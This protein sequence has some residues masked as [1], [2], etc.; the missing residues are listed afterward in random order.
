MR[1]CEALRAAQ[2]DGVVRDKGGLDAPV[3]ER[4]RNFSGGQRQRLGVA[5][6]LCMQPDI[7]ILD[8]ASSALDYA[9]DAA[10]RHAIR[11]LPYHPTVF[12]VSQRASSLRTAD[13]ILVLEDGRLAG[14]G[15]HDELLT[16]CPVYREIAASQDKKE[17]SVG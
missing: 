1:R 6:A 5:R 17:E 12:L 3:E 2:A 8:D 13:Q 7:L 10:M 14:A 4:G 16:N 15:T 11:A 9:T